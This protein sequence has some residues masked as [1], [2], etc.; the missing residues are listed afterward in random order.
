LSAASNAP[1][2]SRYGSGESERQHDTSGARTPAR[3]WRDRLTQ[4]HRAAGHLHDPEHRTRPAR[5][6][7]LEFHLAAL[8]P[9]CGVGAA[10]G[11]GVVRA[12]RDAPSP[13]SQG[14]PPSPTG[15][16]LNQRSSPSRT[17]T[18]LPGVSSSNLV[19]LATQIGTARVAVG[20]ATT[21][22]GYRW[23]RRSGHPR[24]HFRHGA[25]A[26]PLLVSVRVLLSLRQANDV[27]HEAA[28]YRVV[29]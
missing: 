7:V 15:L 9:H 21:N 16:T 22:L 2:E 5:L 26:R 25:A 1:K 18:T 24:P 27:I 20:T 6:P 3:R 28:A 13:A 8:A 23:G 10:W 14:A 12:G 17:A 29:G 4:R 19:A 11:V